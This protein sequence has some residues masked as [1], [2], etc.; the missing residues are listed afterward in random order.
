VLAAG[1]WI[2][3]STLIAFPLQ[4]PLYLAPSSLSP[5]IVMTVLMCAAGMWI[6]WPLMRLSQPPRERVVWCAIVD[7]LA[8]ACLWQLLIWPLRLGT[9]W[10]IE[11]TL[12]IDLHGICG[13]LAVTGIIAAGQAMRSSIARTAAM[14]AC[15]LIGV[16][17]QLPLAAIGLVH[18]NLSSWFPS[19]IPGLLA[20]IN[21]PA[22]L[23]DTVQWNDLLH[24]SIVASVICALGFLI[25]IAAS[26]A[27]DSQSSAVAIGRRVG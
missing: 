17:F 1:G 4:M 8:L 18:P 11:R 15:L 16:G 21:S 3:A 20:R 24:A 5:A 7:A 22:S 2:I 25:A 9:A 27:L 26:R 23:P 13:L 12:L 6:A 14:L 10:P 19:G